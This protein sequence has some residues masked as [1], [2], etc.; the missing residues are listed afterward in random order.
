MV[1]FYIKGDVRTSKAFLENLHIFALAESLGAVE[2]L[3]ELPSLMTHIG[4]TLEEKTRLGVT[5]N[6]I[7]LSVGIEDADDLIEDLSRALDKAS[8][9]T[10]RGPMSHTPETVHA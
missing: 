9:I 10:L 5:D 1:S 6:L 8:S 2:S 7:R 4:L 3:A